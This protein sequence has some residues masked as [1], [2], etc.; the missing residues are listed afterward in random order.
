LSFLSIPIVGFHRNIIIFV[1]STP[2]L[3]LPLLLLL[4][5]LIILLFLRSRAHSRLVVRGF[6]DF[7]R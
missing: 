6:D 5:L 2:V 7:G 3:L 1:I 4:L